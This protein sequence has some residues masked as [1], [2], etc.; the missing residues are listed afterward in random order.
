W[1]SFSAKARK[2]LDVLA[3]GL[4]LVVWLFL[5][6]RMGIGMHDYYQN[7]ELTF[8][9][10]FPVWW[11][12][13][14]SMLPAVVGCIAYLWRVLETLGVVATPPDFVAAKGAH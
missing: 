3:D 8:I 9:L 13:A 12:Y 7:G 6:W 14:L 5:V 4:M 2:V 1:N 10:Q 11:G